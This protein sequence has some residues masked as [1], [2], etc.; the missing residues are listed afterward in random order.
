MQ[1]GAARGSQGNSLA[2]GEWEQRGAG[3]VRSRGGG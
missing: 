3:I 2:H 1:A